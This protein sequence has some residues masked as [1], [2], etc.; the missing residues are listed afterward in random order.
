MKKTT[1]S[2]QGDFL[3][4][5]CAPQTIF[6]LVL[7]G[8][9]L[10]L[11]LVLSQS[12]LRAF[13]WSQM[14]AISMA[15]QWIM[16]PSAAVLCGL[17][18]I[19][20]QL[21]PIISGSLA[22]SIVLIIAA[23]VLAVG[24]W[25][26]TME[27]LFWNFITHMLVAAIFAG[28]M[29]RYLYLQQQLHNQRRAELQSRIHALQARIKPHF[30]FNSMNTIA[31]LI[32]IDPDEAEKAVENLSELFRAS[33]QGTDLVPLVDE[34]SLC[35]SYVAIEQV[36]L[37]DRL[38]VEWQFDKIPEGVKIPSL[39]LQPLIENAIYHGIQ[40]LR[41]GGVVEV[42]VKISGIDLFIQVRNPFPTGLSGDKS[43]QGHKM[44]MSNINHRLQAYYGN[45]ASLMVQ[46]Q[47]DDGVQEYYVV[48]MRLP[49]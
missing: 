14:G 2:I 35:R 39:S 44:A 6:G 13:S 19:F 17:G 31:S 48:A 8:Q 38:R 1:L 29:L 18:K 12:E 11:A 45:K 21:P 30:L 10:A 34:L 43:M 25:L 22:Y 3:P 28:I 33:L 37:G 4:Y 24:Q 15:I 40:K 9:L 16:L 32:A 47:P 42:I 26:F 46:I 5:L 23:V 36:R 41:F 49:L 20:R 7:A 27:L